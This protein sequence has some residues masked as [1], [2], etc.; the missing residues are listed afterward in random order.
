MG[1]FRQIGRKWKQ[2]GID[3]AHLCKQGITRTFN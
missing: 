3:V 1:P 2:L